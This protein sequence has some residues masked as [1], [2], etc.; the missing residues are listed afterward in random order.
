M[1]FYEREDYMK[2]ILIKLSGESLAGSNSEKRGIDDNYVEYISKRIKNP[3]LFKNSIIL[4]P[5]TSSAA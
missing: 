1:S 5:D 4:L 2:T 3:D